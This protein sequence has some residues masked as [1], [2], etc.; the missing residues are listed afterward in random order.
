MSVVGYQPP[1]FFNRGPAPWVRLT[2]FVA[3]CVSLLVVDL[4][5][6][7]LEWVRTGVETV[8]YPLQRVS[9]LPLQGMRAVADHFTSVAALQQENSAMRRSALDAAVRLLR[10]QQ[11]AAENERLRGLLEMRARQPAEGRVADIVFA[12][13]DAFARK[14]I[15]DVGS[16]GGIA[17]GSPVVDAVG[18]VGQVTRVYPLSSE[19]TLLTDKDQAIPVQVVRNGLRAVLFGAGAGA[20]ELR[21]LPANADIRAGDVLAT[22]GLDGIYL[23]GLPVARVTRIDHDAAYA[24]AQIACQPMAGTDSVGQVLV[25][26]KRLMPTL[27]VPE[28]NAAA[29]RKDKPA[30]FRKPKKAEARQP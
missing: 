30:K 8:L 12:A 6:R 4:R 2:F 1:P 13:R 28:D 9:N 17:P 10:E 3:I 18:V 16:Q 19:V 20:M 21:F 11:L 25:L 24:F 15:I 7:T 29:E 26:G 22:S 23:P 27:D 5:Y 14:V